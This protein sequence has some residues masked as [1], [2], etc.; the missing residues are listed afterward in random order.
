MRLRKRLA[1]LEARL[2]ALEQPD[3]EPLIDWTGVPGT[4]GT[5]DI[6]PRSDL[7]RDALPPL[8]SEAVVLYDP[9][10]VD[11]PGVYL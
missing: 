3:E 4:I 2:D 11:C 1:E 5:V 7:W 8:A 10:D 6:W 9:M